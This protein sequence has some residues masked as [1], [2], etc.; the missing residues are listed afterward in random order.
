MQ[1]H[2]SRHVDRWFGAVHGDWERHGSSSNWPNGACYSG[3]FSCVSLEFRE[4]HEFALEVLIVFGEI[5]EHQNVTFQII[6]V[7]GRTLELN[8]RR[9]ALFL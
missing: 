6:D 8:G 9:D 4:D 1:V 2:V 7:G 5:L 3:C